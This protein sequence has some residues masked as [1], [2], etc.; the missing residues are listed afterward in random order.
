MEAVRRFRL[1]KVKG[2]DCAGFLRGKKGAMP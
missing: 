1:F 2:S